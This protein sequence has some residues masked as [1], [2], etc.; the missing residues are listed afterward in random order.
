M[1]RWGHFHLLPFPLF[2]V[3]V[4]TFAAKS[5]QT[6]FRFL[7][8]QFI[9]SLIDLLHMCK[10]LTCSAYLI[11]VTIHLVVISERFCL[12]ACPLPYEKRSP[13]YVSF[14]ILTIVRGDV[15]QPRFVVRC[16]LCICE[17]PWHVFM[18]VWMYVCLRSRSSLKRGNPPKTK[19]DPSEE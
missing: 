2:L 18:N 3:A 6:A 8:I 13:S 17:M 9:F 12:R 14:N 11:P 7:W 1:T 16:N 10:Y 4:G 5:I 15:M 19:K